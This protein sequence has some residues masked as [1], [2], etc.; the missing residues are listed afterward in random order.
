MEFVE[1]RT[2]KQEVRARPLP[3]EDALY[4]AI[5]TAQGLQAAH[6]TV[7]LRG[8]FLLYLAVLR[9]GCSGGLGSAVA[10]PSVPRGSVA[11]L[12]WDGPCRQR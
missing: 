8:C 1:G 4:I 11:P 6:E 2:V 5:Q 7:R 10:I 12:R 3:L 9:Q